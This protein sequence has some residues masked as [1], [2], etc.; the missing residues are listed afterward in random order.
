MLL[1]PL[2]NSIFTSLHE[3]AAYDEL[4]E[5]SSTDK[6][7]NLLK[8]IRVPGESKQLKDDVVHQAIEEAVT[9]SA[10]DYNE[11][12]NKPPGRFEQSVLSN[13]GKK[14]QQRGIHARR[15]HHKNVNYSIIFR[16]ANIKFLFL[17]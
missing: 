3:K 17:T 13:T 6:N 11:N 10:P 15:F 2:N 5:F 1:L 12:D 16:F 4:N 8:G 9:S 7:D 14:E